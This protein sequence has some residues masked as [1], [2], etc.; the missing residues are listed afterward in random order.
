M[1]LSTGDLSKAKDLLLT[2]KLVDFLWSFCRV[3]LWFQL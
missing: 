1:L 3:Y 2:V